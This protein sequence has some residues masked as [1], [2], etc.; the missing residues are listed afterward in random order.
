M[1]SLPSPQFPPVI[2]EVPFL[3]DLQCLITA[4][5]GGLYEWNPVGPKKGDAFL[6]RRRVHE[7]VG[8][9]IADVTVSNPTVKAAKALLES[10]TIPQFVWPAALPL[11]EW[12]SQH[13]A[14]FE[15]SSILELGSGVGVGGMSVLS[16]ASPNIV[17]LS[18]CSSVSLAMI[19]CSLRTWVMPI[20]DGRVLR[21]QHGGARC[22]VAKL[23]WGNA[24][25]L[26]AVLAEV[27][28][29]EFDF[30][31]GSDVFYF[32]KSLEDGLATARSAL[33]EGGRFLCGSFVRSDRMETDLERLP[34]LLGFKLD[35]V[36]IPADNA[37]WGKVH[38][39]EAT[40]DDLAF[41]L[42]TWI[43]M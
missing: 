41:R 24:A 19:T 13:A 6:R 18:D 21:L 42:Y 23:R 26:V 14:L 10:E 31:V 25:D 22:A 32:Q 36:C 20:S 34:E 3:Q 7:L 2:G 15:G 40:E 8:L 27:G 9:Q 5:E 4:A 39:R 35:S 37:D 28:L 11:S 30:V 16:F 12:V 33:R 1:H 17:V 43:K 38:G 29:K